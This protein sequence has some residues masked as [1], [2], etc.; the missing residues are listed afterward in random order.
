MSNRAAATQNLR[1]TVENAPNLLK[2]YLH[3]N[4]LPP[5]SY[6]VHSQQKDTHGQVHV[7]YRA[8]VK[9]A[10]FPSTE[11]R[12]RALR[13]S[14]RAT[15]PTTCVSST[16]SATVLRPPRAS[17]GTGG[18]RAVRP[19]GAVKQEDGNPPAAPQ[20]FKYNDISLKFPI[21]SRNKVVEDFILAHGGCI[22][23]EKDAFFF[24]FDLDVGQSPESYA[25]TRLIEQ[26]EAGQ[27]GG[28]TVALSA[29]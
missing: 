25:D 14:P 22:G 3:D 9:L 21:P 28:L 20:V 13:P 15:Q 10:V 29:D 16:T 11:A 27:K 1:L 19:A 12:S 6:H 26:I 5:A 17:I 2:A 4:G 24:I 23:G 7:L 18:S 8:T